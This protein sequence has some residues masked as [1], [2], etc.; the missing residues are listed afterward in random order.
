M[1]CQNVGT[2][3]RYKSAIFLLVALE[4]FHV[5]PLSG[6]GEPPAV[7]D[8]FSQTILNSNISFSVAMKI[9]VLLRHCQP[10]NMHNMQLLTQ[11]VFKAF[12]KYSEVFLML[13]VTYNKEPNFVFTNGGAG[14]SRDRAFHLLYTFLFRALLFKI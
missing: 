4:I 14:F 5:E 3:L 2:F 13:P 1:V 9:T 10:S 8:I 6:R 12:L 7:I 11:N